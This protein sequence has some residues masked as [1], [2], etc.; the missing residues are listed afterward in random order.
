M[1]KEFWLQRWKGSDHLEDPGVDKQMKL[2]QML[3]E[4]DQPV[5]VKTPIRFSLLV[6]VY[7]VHGMD[8]YIFLMNEVTEINIWFHTGLCS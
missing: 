7:G 2:Q 6:E 5:G 4:V 8:W 1:R 3:M